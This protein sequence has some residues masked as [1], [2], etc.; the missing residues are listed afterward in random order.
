MPKSDLF[1]RG[2]MLDYERFITE[3]VAE[4][5]EDLGGHPV[6]D[7]TER[8]PDPTAWRVRELM[9]RYLS[10]NHRQVLEDTYF[11]QIPISEQARQKG[12]SRQAVQNMLGR[13]KENLVR[14]IAEK[15]R[16][17]AQ[18]PDEEI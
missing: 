7:S 13:A 4:N 2:R 9:R 10:D 17:V 16:E 18:V 15:G 11:L 3:G 6:W 1:R 5:V 8:K 14:A 12:T